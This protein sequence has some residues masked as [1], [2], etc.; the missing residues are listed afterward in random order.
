MASELA[1]SVGVEWPPTIYVCRSC[2]GFLSPKYV[3]V[4]ARYI[5]RKD[6]GVCGA[7]HTATL[8]LDECERLCE[9][10]VFELRVV[11][12]LRMNKEIY[13]VESYYPPPATSTAW[14]LL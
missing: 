1:A 7:C 6:P 13:G 8:E 11:E 2:S 9:E 10:L 14:K 3:K 4:I 12:G 5:E